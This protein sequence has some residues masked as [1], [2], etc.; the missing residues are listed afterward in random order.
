MFRLMSQAAFD[1]LRQRLAEIADL[2]KTAALLSWD[3]QVMMPPRRRGDPRRAARDG[4]PHRA[5]E[6][7]LGRGRPPA[8]RPAR[9]RRAA[10][11]RLVRGEPDPRRRAATGR[12]RA[13][14]RPTCARRCRASASLANPVWVAARRDNDFASFLP[15][16]A[17]EPR[18]AQALHRLLRGRR[19]AV[20]HRARRLRARHEDGRGAAHL[21]L[22]EG[23]PGAAR[24][25]GRRAGAGRE[26]REDVRHRRAEDL[27]ARGRARV[28]LHRRRRGASIRPC[29]RSRPAP[30]STDIRITTRYFTDGLEGLFG[31]M[32]E[33]GHGLYEHQ[34]DPSLE[35]SPLARGVSLGL[36]ESQSRMWENLVGRS[37]PFWRRFFPRAAGALPR[38]ARRARRRELV[39]RGERRRAVAD[40]R[41]GRRGDLQPAHH[42]A[43]RARAGDA[44]RR[45]SRSSSCPR[46]GTG[47]CGS[48]S[49]SRCRT[50]RSASCRTCTGR[51]ARSATSRPTRSAT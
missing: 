14:C 16:A 17:Q 1:D 5:H 24:Q 49:A 47:A 32:H 15:G 26:A 35:R 48:T 44:R 3:Q 27:R 40:P 30:A 36:H 29:T 38:R 33:F 7:H 10:R 51:A 19:R 50:T 43:L 9:L 28:R 41:R 4:R 2:G 39:P 25:G 11:V 31:T 37:Q 13:R 22:P 46:S 34:V 20:R 42:P 6:V 45:R 23:A 8:R 18:P 12:R 21:R